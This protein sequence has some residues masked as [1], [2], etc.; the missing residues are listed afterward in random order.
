MILEALA[1]KVRPMTTDKKGKK[2]VKKSAM[3]EFQ[4]LE[5]NKFL[6][7]NNEVFDFDNDFV[8]DLSW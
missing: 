3:R 8:P 7:E 6:E 5:I 2:A 4:R 1:E